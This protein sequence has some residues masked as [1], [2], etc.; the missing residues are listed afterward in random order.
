MGISSKEKKDDENF[1]YTRD[2]H[3]QLCDCNVAMRIVG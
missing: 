1:L 3:E 2:G